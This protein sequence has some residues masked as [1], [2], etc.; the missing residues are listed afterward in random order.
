MIEL[1]I[2]NK[3]KQ[4]EPIYRSFLVMYHYLANGSFFPNP[5]TPLKLRLL[6]NLIGQLNGELILVRC[7]QPMKTLDVK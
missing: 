3:M 4:T 6:S 5:T 1:E 2:R 7:E